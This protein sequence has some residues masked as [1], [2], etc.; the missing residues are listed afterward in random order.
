MH[1]V[2]KHITLDFCVLKRYLQS[3]DFY[4]GAGCMVGQHLKERLFTQRVVFPPV[5][6]K[7]S[8]CE[9]ETVCFHQ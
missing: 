5:Q 9:A 3:V 6:M 2:L 1:R 8:C 4:F 7:M